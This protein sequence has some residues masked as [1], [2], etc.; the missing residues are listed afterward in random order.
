MHAGRFFLNFSCCSVAARVAKKRVVVLDD[1]KTAGSGDKG[2]GSDY[3]NTLQLV[4]E[5]LGSGI[6]N[7]NQAAHELEQSYNNGQFYD[8][9]EL[10]QGQSTV[11]AACSDG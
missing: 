10:R 5:E 4:I 7:A 11:S 6:E 9:D 2:Y 3:F 1:S 8:Q